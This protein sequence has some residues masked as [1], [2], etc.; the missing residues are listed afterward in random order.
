MKHLMLALTTVL[1]MALL[2]SSSGAQG[3]VIYPAKGQ[4]SEQTPGITPSDWRVRKNSVRY[5]R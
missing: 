4:S 1:S 5:A 2:V 3:P